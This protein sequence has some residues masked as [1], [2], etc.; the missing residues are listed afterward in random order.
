MPRD[1]KTEGL[2]AS[3]TRAASLQTYTTVRFLVDRERVADA[4]QAYAYFRWVD[5]WL[6]EPA[7]QRSDRLAF[8][9]RQAA[10][11]D[12]CYRRGAAQ[13]TALEED[14]LVALV[15]TDPD[16]DSG[17]HTYIR[18]MLAVMAFDAE[19]RGRLISQL[20]LDHYQHSLAMAVTEALHYFIGHRLA[21]PHIPI[22]YLA[23]EGAHIAHMLRDTIEDNGLGYFNIPREYIKANGISALD[24]DADAYRSWVRS[25]VVLAR[26]YFAAGRVY[27]SQVKSLR[28]RLAGY[29]YMARFHGV[30]DAIEMDGYLLRPKYSESSGPRAAAQ[31]GWSVLWSAFNAQRAVPRPGMLSTR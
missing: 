29:A 25:R 27:L 21:A 14:M 10:L 4:Y 23:A 11:I 28:C 26:N 13:T 22:R 30:L 31:M 6:D 2:G 19:R 9:R 17:L 15:R 7:R 5:D 3:I 20:E 24:I 16:Q 8:V 18:H 12:E 1:V